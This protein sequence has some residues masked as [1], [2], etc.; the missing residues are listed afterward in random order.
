MKTNLE[1]LK[2]SIGNVLALTSKLPIEKLNEIPAGQSNN[3]I[4]NVAHLLVT[5]KGLIY[6]LS[7]NAS[8]LD[9]TFVDK[10]KKGTKPHGNLSETECEAIFEMFNQQFDVLVNDIEKGIFKNYSPYMTS[11]NFEISSIENAVA[12]N[13]VHYGLHISTILRL[14]KVLGA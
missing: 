7:G 3:L 12:F 13:N 5:Q 14:K 10:Y 1:I 11:Y 2:V 9:Q 4:W 6:G 8:G